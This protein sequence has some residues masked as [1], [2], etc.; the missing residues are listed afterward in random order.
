MRP[1]RREDR[2]VRPAAA[3]ELNHRARRR[4]TTPIRTRTAVEQRGI[5]HRWTQMNTNYSSL[6][7]VPCGYDSVPGFDILSVFICV[8]LWFLPLR[9]RGIAHTDLGSGGPDVLRRPAGRKCQ[10]T[11]RVS[12]T[13]LAVPGTGGTH[14][15]RKIPSLVRVFVRAL[16]VAFSARIMPANSVPTAW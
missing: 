12:R 10:D 9:R 2:T 4:I 6:G 1:P 11:A 16:R 3:T 15:L 7:I 14:V 5:N 8:H 13:C